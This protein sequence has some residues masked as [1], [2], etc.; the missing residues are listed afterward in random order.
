MARRQKISLGADGVVSYKKMQPFVPSIARIRPAIKLN[1]LQKLIQTKC[2]S[3]CLVRGEGIGDVLM[4]TPTIHA[5]RELFANNCHITFATNT[6]YLEGAL[7]KVLK[8]NPDIDHI[9]ERQLLD[10]KEYDLVVNLQCPSIAFEK[11]RAIPPNRVDLFANHAGVKLADPRPRYFI[12]KEEVE[13]GEIFLQGVMPTERLVLVQ[14]FASSVNR[15]YNQRKL[16]SA[17]ILL[18][19]TY[20][21]RSVIVTHDTDGASDTLWDNVPGSIYLR[22]VDIRGI[23]G[24]MVHCDL[25]LCPD[26]SILHLAGCLG[27]PCVSLFGP[28]PPQSRINYY[29]ETVAIWEGEDIPACPCWYERCPMGYMCWERITKESIVTK[30]IER[31]QSSKKVDIVHVLDQIRPLEIQTEVV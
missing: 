18:F 20:G 13:A 9:I 19:E 25:V 15:T 22:N 30:C 10:E 11:P 6:R 2:P 28:T 23:G 16:K 8:H 14:P 24:V 29:P 5:M 21:I 17:C 26:S 27:V 7:V 3:I 1:R 12:Q 4:T 31:L